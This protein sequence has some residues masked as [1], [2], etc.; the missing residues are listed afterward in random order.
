MNHVSDGEYSK[1]V[2]A[3]IKRRFDEPGRVQEGA[4]LLTY[5]TDDI[6]AAENGGKLSVSECADWF[7]QR[8]DED[9]AK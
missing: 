4:V 2:R 6:R 1:A 7:I 9:Y 3:E 5:S 8:S